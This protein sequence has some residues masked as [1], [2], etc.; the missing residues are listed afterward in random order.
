VSLGYSA[1]I[2]LQL[3][4]GILLQLPWLIHAEANYLFDG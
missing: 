1:D 3:A 2:Y 4:D